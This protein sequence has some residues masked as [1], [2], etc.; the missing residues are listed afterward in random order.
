MPLLGTDLS[1]TRSFRGELIA[2]LGGGSATWPLAARAQQGAKV[3]LRQH[4]FTG[5]A[6]HETAQY[7]F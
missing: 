7:Q 3:R 6:L 1:A 5:I 4:S 2:L